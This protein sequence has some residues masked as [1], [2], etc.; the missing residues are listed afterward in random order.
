[1]KYMI[2]YLIDFAALALL[3]AF[4]FFRKWKIKGRDRL[5]VNT[6][7]YVCISFFC[8]L[9]YPDADHHIYPVYTESSL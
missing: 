6:V 4:V 7:M 1:M 8:A 9:F 2:K 5:L 3:Y